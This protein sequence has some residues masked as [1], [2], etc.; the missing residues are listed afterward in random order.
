[1][2][3]KPAK[4]SSEVTKVMTSKFTQNSTPLI[5]EYKYDGERSQ[6]HYSDNKLSFFSRQFDL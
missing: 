4:E 1:M 3:G 6:V 5:A 2:V